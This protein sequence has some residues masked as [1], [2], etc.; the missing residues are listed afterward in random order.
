MIHYHNIDVIYTKEAETADQY[1]EK[2]A[3][4]LSKNNIVK[5]ATS[6]GIEQIITYGAGAI[7]VSASDLK[8]LVDE[9]IKEMR[10]E[11]SL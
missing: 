1:I 11:Y 8:Y 4:A 6:D 5:V 7:R 2:A 10:E 9:S 3:H